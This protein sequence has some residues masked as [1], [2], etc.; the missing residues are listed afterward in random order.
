MMSDLKGFQQA[1]RTILP[2]KEMFNEERPVADLNKA[3]K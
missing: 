2:I 1:W 3:T